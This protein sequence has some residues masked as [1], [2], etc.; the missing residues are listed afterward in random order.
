MA[1]H[2]ATKAPT[3]SRSP[4]LRWPTLAFMTIACT[5]SIAQLSAAASYG[6]GAITLYLIPAIFFMIPVALVAA[7]LATAWDGGVFSWVSEGLGERSGFQAQWL[8]WIQSVAL[9]PSLLS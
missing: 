6:L 7:E 4:L 2:S 9:Y 1:R 8:Q 3:A 5:G